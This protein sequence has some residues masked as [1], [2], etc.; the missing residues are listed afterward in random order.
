VVAAYFLLNRRCVK[1]IAAY[2][3]LDSAANR[4]SDWGTDQRIRGT[5]KRLLGRVKEGLGRFTGN[6][7]LVDEGVGD[8]VVGGVKDTAGRAAHVASDV[9]RDLNG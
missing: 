5:G 7:D 6:P 4:T 9:I 3:E 1:D 8:Q 2:D